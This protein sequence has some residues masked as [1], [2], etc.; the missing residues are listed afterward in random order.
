MPPPLAR[1]Q[2]EFLGWECSTDTPGAVRFYT[3]TR[4]FDDEGTLI[5]E[6]QLCLEAV[7]DG[8]QLRFNYSEVAAGCPVG[9][10][11]FRAMR[12]PTT[13]IPGVGDAQE[14]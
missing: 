12:V 13:L 8:D 4:D 7:I 2:D 14:C 3:H 9:T 10:D 6:R 11:R 5:K 1:P